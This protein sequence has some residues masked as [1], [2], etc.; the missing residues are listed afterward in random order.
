M[1]ALDLSNT[2]ILFVTNVLNGTVAANGNI[3]SEGSIVR[4]VLLTPEGLT[5]RELARTT[6][7]DAFQERTDPAALV[8]G[9]TGLALTPNGRLFV[10][11]TLQNRIAVIPN[12]LFRLDDAKAGITVSE[13]GALN[14]PLGIALAP[15]GNILTV[16]GCD[17]NMVETTTGGRQ[18]AVH[19]VDVSGQG[20]GT[21]F[22]L[23]VA[24]NG[25]SVYFVHDGNNTLNLFH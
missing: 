6:I 4:T 18:V 15:N 22:G 11:D 19:S 1:T 16:N 20:A 3:I 25:N 10:A 12:A 9:P 13:G 21:L 14:A 7:A 8:I 17:G 23:A 24:P 2:A 5:P